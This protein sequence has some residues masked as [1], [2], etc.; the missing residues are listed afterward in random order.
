MS[1]FIF[2]L[3][4]LFRAPAFATLPLPLV[5]EGCDDEDPRDGFFD[6][7]SETNVGFDDAIGFQSLCRLFFERGDDFSPSVWQ[8]S[9]SQC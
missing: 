4:F 8:K 7:F 9:A 2:I 6:V 5:G 1:R 3:C